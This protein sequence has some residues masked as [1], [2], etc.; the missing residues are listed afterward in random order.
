M[1]INPTNGWSMYPRIGITP[2]IPWTLTNF[3]IWKI[4][5]EMAEVMPE[6]GPLPAIN[7]NICLGTSKM[8][9]II[10]KI[11]KIKIYDKKKYLNEK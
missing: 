10:S 3:R 1:A 5:S 6:N 7:A 4:T 2:T 11:P 8:A 9:P